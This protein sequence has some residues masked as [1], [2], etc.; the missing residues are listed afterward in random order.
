ML[1]W[2]ERLIRRRKE[3]GEFGFGKLGV[4]D[5]GERSVFAHSCDWDGRVVVALHNLADEEC[6]ARVESLLGE[7][8]IDVAEIWS[9]REY[10]APKNGRVQL[11]AYGYRWFRVL[12]EGQELLL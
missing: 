5:V 12:K 6:D 8:V 4:L 1:N 3:A 10:K 2:M 9:D 11:G 7:D